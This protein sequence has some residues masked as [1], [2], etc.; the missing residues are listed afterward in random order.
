MFRTPHAPLQEN[1]LDSAVRMYQ[2]G[3]M[4]DVGEVVEFSV[5][6]T[7][8]LLYEVEAEM[9][10]EKWHLSWYGVGVDG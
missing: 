4:G 8:A 1:V 9:F 6:A 5:D 3:K 2:T 10:G 7:S